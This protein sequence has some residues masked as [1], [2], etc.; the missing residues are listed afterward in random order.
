MAHQDSDERFDQYLRTEHAKEFGQIQQ[1]LDRC[2][3]DEERYEFCVQTRDRL[4]GE[5]TGF[6]NLI[7][8]A[9]SLFDEKCLQYK[10]RK[11]APRKG[12]DNHAKDTRQRDTEE[13]R[14]FVGV[15][16]TAPIRSSKCLTALKGISRVWGP[17][18]IR[19]Y[20][21]CDDKMTG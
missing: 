10:R 1:G 14:R 3:T 19:Q 2:Q 13:W 12:K 11:A 4:M 18:V 9:D 5:H 20:G 21:Y 6:E 16:A 15:A 17:K 8:L 7:A